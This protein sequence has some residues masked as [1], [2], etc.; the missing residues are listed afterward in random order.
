MKARQETMSGGGENLVEIDGLRVS[1]RTYGGSVKAV[2]GI[3]LSIRKGECLAIV[4]ESGCGKSVTAQTI[5]RLIPSPPAA[6]E[7]S[8]RFE[9]R[10]IMTMSERKIKTL[11][12]A[13]IGMIFQDPMTS[14]DPTMPIGKQIMEGLLEHNRWMK[15]SE[16]RRRVVEVLGMV[17]IPEPERQLKRYAYEFSGGMRQRAVIAMA[18]VCKPKLLIADEPTTALDVTTQAQILDL[19]RN[20]KDELHTAVLLIT[21]DMGVVSNMAD[22][23]AVFYAGEV[24]E[25]GTAED[26]FYSPGHPYTAALLRSRP[27]LDRDRTQCLIS[28]PGA[29]PDLFAPPPGCA[30]APRCGCALEICRRAP[31]RS[32]RL[33]EEHQVSC[34]LYHEKARI[35]H[36]LPTRDRLEAEV[37]HDR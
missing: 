12:G 37:C 30:F 15:R 5:M 31:P 34:W 21:H 26:I 3:S 24:A 4:G 9:G 28:I 17:G 29:P 19:I 6:I 32:F 10:E 27:R 2:R 33:G 14:L 20:L 16:A 23:I 18:V 11:R 22:R 1:F 8:V 13:E 25:E 7:G 36:G 35:R